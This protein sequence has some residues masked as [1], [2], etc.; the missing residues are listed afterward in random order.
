[1]PVKKQSHAASGGPGGGGINSRATAKLTTYHQ[2]Y[3]SERINP[4]GVA[5][6]GSAVG[7]HVSGGLGGGGKETNYRGDPVR[8][9]PMLNRE[10]GNECAV[11]TV[12]GPGG[13]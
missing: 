12:A 8:M 4:G 11:R 6:Y 13:S 7:S 10:L 2:G 9:G 3:P 5:Q 1:M